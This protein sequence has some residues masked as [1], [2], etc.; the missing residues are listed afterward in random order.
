MKEAGLDLGAAKGAA[1]AAAGGM[2]GLG[3]RQL[4]AFLAVRRRRG[5]PVCWAGACLLGTAWA[6]YDLA[7][8]S[9][10]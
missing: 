6:A 1:V 10:T 5:G 3:A 7:G 8:P 2:A 4:I 9:N